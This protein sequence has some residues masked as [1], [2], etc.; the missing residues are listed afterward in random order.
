MEQGD[1]FGQYFF[2]EKVYITL[3]LLHLD[4]VTTQTTKLIILP[5]ELSKTGQIIPKAVLE[6]G[7]AFVFSI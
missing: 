1:L 5:R 6:G 7:F 3:Q 2:L 4:Y